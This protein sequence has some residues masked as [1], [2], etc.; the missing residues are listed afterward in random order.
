MNTNAP[1]TS[2]KVEKRSLKARIARL[3]KRIDKMTPFINEFGVERIRQLEK[4]FR[5]LEASTPKNTFNN[6]HN[7]F[8]NDDQFIPTTRE[9]LSNQ[10][11][12]DHLQSLMS[13]NVHFNLTVSPEPE[14]DQQIEPDPT[15]L[16]RSTYNPD[17]FQF[18]QPIHRLQPIVLKTQFQKN[19]TRKMER[20]QFRAMRKEFI[21]REIIEK[22]TTIPDNKPIANKTPDSLTFEP[23]K[24]R[25]KTTK[26]TTN[27]HT[28]TEKIPTK[29]ITSI[30][31]SKLTTSH[32]PT[33]SKP[34]KRPHSPIN[35]KII[36]PKTP[37]NSKLPSTTCNYPTT[38]EHTTINNNSKLT[39]THNPTTPKT[40]NTS[41]TKIPNKPQIQSTI[42][43]SEPRSSR[44]PTTRRLKTFKRLKTHPY[45]NPPSITTVHAPLPT[46]PT[47]VTTQTTTT[48][49]KTLTRTPISISSFNN[50]LSGSS[51][52]I[53]KNNPQL[54]NHKTTNKT[55][56]HLGRKYNIVKPEEE[57]TIPT[58]TIS[59][60][61]S[62][63]ENYFLKLF[64][65]EEP[66]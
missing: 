53:T 11:K 35:N 38:S 20:K 14:Q 2:K 45:D 63:D 25:L 65:K 36:S 1:S 34:V 13:I 44:S 58:I 41:T 60:S 19:H 51:I 3:R 31:P 15:A 46:P 54:D 55:D 17:E 6:T 7:P 4:E 43:T 62:E 37:N 52:T 24:A 26:T 8:D 16:P 32:N 12:M 40:I 30:N 39:P 50:T 66:L 42:N 29:P 5:E 47:I 48:Q 10:R 33:T 22:P 28:T 9:D 49:I 61:E 57:E 21:S 27:N 18:I 56:Y 23:I 64:I 59:E